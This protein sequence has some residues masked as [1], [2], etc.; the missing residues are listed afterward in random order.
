VAAEA[1]PVPAKEAMPRE[2]DAWGRMEEESKPA[3][4]SREAWEYLK[5]DTWGA[6]NFFDFNSF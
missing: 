6:G 2:P 1:E 3:A 4:P 5:T